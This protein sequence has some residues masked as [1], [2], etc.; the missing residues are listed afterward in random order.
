MIL[1][2]MFIAAVFGLD[3][4]STLSFQI[5][6]ITLVL[7]L[8][9]MTY[10][11]FYRRKFSVRRLLP[12]YGTVGQ[13][14][15]YSCRVNNLNKRDCKQIRVTDDLK[16]EFPDMAA[17]AHFRDP[18]D[19]KRNFVDRF[20][21]Y[22]RLVSALRKSRGA[23]IAAVTIEHISRESDIDVEI[24]LTPLR[25]GYLD[26]DRIRLAS[27]DPMGLF[28]AQ[29]SYSQKNR[30]LILPKL[31]DTPRLDLPGR[32]VYQTGG[33]NRASLT[34][35]SQ[36]FVSLREYRP[37]DPMRSIHWR[38]YAKRGEPIV[39][40]Y[41]DEYV[42]RFGLILDTYLTAEGS[43]ETFEKAVSLAASFMFNQT[44]QD[45]L[46]DLMFIGNEAY[47]YTSGRGHSNIDSILEVLAC[48][49][50]TETENLD[51]LQALLDEHIHEC[52]ALICILLEV[53][54]E[55]IELLKLL[56]EYRLPVK[57][58]ILDKNTDRL[59]KKDFNHVKLHFLDPA[60]LQKELNKINTSQMAEN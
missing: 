10:A 27:A 25:R 45:A 59:D 39:K 23:S 38:S 6:A 60:A 29:K 30:L 26:F 47:R 17:L 48:I 33:T 24:K 44:Q 3:T 50:P 58:L 57:A 4:R 21:G 1:G 18:L 13:P 31:Y 42:I 5:F 54:D 19:K 56:D 12:E 43:N 32:R 53:D 11:L 40:E 36:E 15:Y 51:R 37:G 22:P 28:H 52:C 34:G 2:V 55:K 14:L 35:D 41:Q 20:F 7:I 16:T 49:Q 46:L 9:A 8:T